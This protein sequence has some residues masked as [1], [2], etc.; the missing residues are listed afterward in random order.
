MSGRVEKG[1][2]P[3]GVSGAP[4]VEWQRKEREEKEEREGVRGSVMQPRLS[5]LFKND[6]RFPAAAASL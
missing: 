1:K 4:I 3:Q 6:P 2:G 5:H